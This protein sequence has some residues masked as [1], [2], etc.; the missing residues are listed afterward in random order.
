[1]H[2]SLDFEFE[3]LKLSTCCNLGTT[4]TLSIINKPEK[5]NLLISVEVWL[6]VY[7]TILDI[8]KEMVFAG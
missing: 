5:S 4:Q 6:L 7:N 2:S 8:K 1:M 3:E